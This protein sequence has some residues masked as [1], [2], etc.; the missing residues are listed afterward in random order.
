MANVSDDA[1]PFPC[2]GKSAMRWRGS[3][4]LAPRSSSANPR[5]DADKVYGC[6]RQASGRVPLR[7]RRRDGVRSGSRRGA[8]PARSAGLRRCRSMTTDASGRRSSP[9]RPSR[10]DRKAPSARPAFSLQRYKFD[11]DQG[12][13]GRLA[14]GSRQCFNN[15]LVHNKQLN[16]H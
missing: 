1:P 14:Q 10:R 11:S 3:K 4:P 9:G 8:H 5:R 12:S 7:R 16:W 6:R 13:G 2:A 15:P